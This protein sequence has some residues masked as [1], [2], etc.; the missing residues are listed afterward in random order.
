M[1]RK[2]VKAIAKG[3]PGTNFCNVLHGNKPT[4]AMQV[5]KVLILRGEPGTRGK[6]DGTGIAD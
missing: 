1:A 2:W 4:A 5:R 3:V 6:L